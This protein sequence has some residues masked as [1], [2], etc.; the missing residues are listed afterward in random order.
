MKNILIVFLVLG[1]S[2]CTAFQ[3][4][5]TATKSQAIPLKPVYQEP[6]MKIGK[7]QAVDV[8]VQLSQE[9][10]AVGISANTQQSDTLLKMALLM[11]MI[12]GVPVEQINWQDKEKVTKLTADIKRM[13]SEY[14]DKVLE[15]EELLKELAY[16]K[17]ALVEMQKRNSWLSTLVGWLTAGAIVLGILCLLFPSVGVPIFFSL[18]RRTKKA[19][20]KIAQEAVAMGK[21]QLAQVVTAIEESKPLLKEKAPDAYATML[22]NLQKATDSKTRD[23]INE[24]K[25][26]VRR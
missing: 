7:Q 3:I 23:V 20:E 24:I 13:E 4:G 12:E 9:A 11:Q 16:N 19:G 18:I 15:W 17:D 8:I 25:I 14:R 2:S 5:G 21:E 10:D 1:L 26:K 6:E 22:T